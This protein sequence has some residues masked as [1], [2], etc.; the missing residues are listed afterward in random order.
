VP[1]GP[2]QVDSVNIHRL[3]RSSKFLFLDEDGMPKTCSDP[4]RYGLPFTFCHGSKDMEDECA[5]WCRCV[6]QFHHGA[7]LNV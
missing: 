6:Y 1:G 5:R 2:E 3:S 4:F 7:E